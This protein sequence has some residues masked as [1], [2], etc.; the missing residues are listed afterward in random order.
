M[1]NCKSLYI[2][3]G[4]DQC[5]ELDISGEIADNV[6][7]VKYLGDIFNS[8]GN[9]NDLIESRVK[10]GKQKIGVIQAFC[11]EIA[12]RNYEIDIMLQLYESIFLGTVLF[13]CQSRTNLTNTHT[14]SLQAS[15]NELSKANN[16][17]TIFHIQQRNFAKTWNFIYI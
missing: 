1:D 8:K 9:N 7:K 14:E 4:K 13:S 3:Y 10:T 12:L 15:S 5:I 17:R 6:D 11:K 16:V 2:N